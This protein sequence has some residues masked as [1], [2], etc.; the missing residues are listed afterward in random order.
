MIG[1]FA[2]RGL[3]ARGARAAGLLVSRR[4]GEVPGR[5][6]GPR[7]H[8]ADDR[9]RLPPPRAA[10]RAERHRRGLA[11]AGDGRGNGAL[12][13]GARPARRLRGRGRGHDR[14]VPAGGRGHGRADGRRP[15]QAAR[16]LRGD[17]QPA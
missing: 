12:L 3:P 11:A 8:P 5:P 13:A 7:P 2:E 16:L 9:P 14:G 15:A 6:A 1:G 17:P 10:P 4:P